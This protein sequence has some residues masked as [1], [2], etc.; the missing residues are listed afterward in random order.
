MAQFYKTSK[1]NKTSSLNNRTETVTV[2]KLDAFGLGIAYLNKLPIFIQNALPNETVKIR[3]IEHKKNYAKAVVIERLNDHADRI[4]PICSHYSNCGGCQLQHIPLQWQKEIKKTNI[5]HL[6]KNNSHINV[7]IESMIW[8]ESEQYGYRRRSR[9]AFEHKNKQSRLGFKKGHSHTIVDIQECSILVPSLQRLLTPLKMAFSKLN[10]PHKI[11]FIDLIHVENKNSVV[12]HISKPIDSEERLQLV[13]FAQQ[14]DLNLLLK[15]NSIELLSGSDKLSYRIDDLTLYFSPI[16][17]V[18]V[19][20]HINLAMIELAKKWLAIKEHDVILD[21]FCGMGNFSFPLATVT[22]KV[23]GVEL[24]NELI[25]QANKNNHIN[26]S[27]IRHPIEFFCSDLSEVKGKQ[28]WQEKNINK[29]LLDP[30]REGA[31]EIVSSIIALSPELILYVSCNPATL[32]RDCAE[33]MSSERYELE[34]IAILD[35]FPQTKH[36]ESMVLFKRS[37]K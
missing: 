12:I 21:L 33:I 24:S 1:Q 25:A 13:E 30:A 11:K 36:I 29:V 23:I 15:L 19:N 3:I 9:L 5:T 34:K 28:Q 14:H 17:F 4:E 31:K 35:M 22:K 8:V 32:S 2:E 6:L 20:P 16:D 27:L 18:Q 26:H 37:S 10:E 7:D